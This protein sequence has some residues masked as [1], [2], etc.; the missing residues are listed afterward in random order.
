MFKKIPFR[1]WFRAARPPAL[2]DFL[3][4]DE[5]SSGN[6]RFRARC[7]RP[8]PDEP[9]VVYLRSLRGPRDIGQSPSMFTRLGHWITG[10]NG[11]S[12][13]LAE[14]VRPGGR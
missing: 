10:E 2:G 12:L 4:V 6:A 11:G 5:A 1:N 3:R 13:A 14:T 9:R 7:G 8:P